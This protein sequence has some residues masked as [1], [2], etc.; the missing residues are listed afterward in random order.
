MRNQPS[1]LPSITFGII[2]FTV[3]RMQWVEWYTECTC[4][5]KTSHKL[6]LF[7]KVI[8]IRLTSF[9][10]IIVVF[11]LTH[12]FCNLSNTPVCDSIFQAFSYR[13]E[14]FFFI[15]RNISIFFQPVKT[16]FVQ[17]HRSLHCLI[18]SFFILIGNKAFQE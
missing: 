9:D 10:E 6:S 13:L 18:S 16:S 2:I 5:R 15:V 11:G 3:S 8:F 1:I 14:C 17:H 12:F 4:R 7:I